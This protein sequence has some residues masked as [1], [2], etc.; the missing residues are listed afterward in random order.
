MTIK[1]NK[2]GWKRG[3]VLLGGGVI[4]IV[5]GILLKDSLGFEALRENQTALTALRDANPWLTAGAFVVFYVL[6]VAF[7]LPGATLATLTGGFLFG[8]ASAVNSRRARKKSTSRSY[9]K[10]SS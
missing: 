8:T 1:G 2:T 5:G 10:G 6:V 4:A 7:S 3:L 9:S